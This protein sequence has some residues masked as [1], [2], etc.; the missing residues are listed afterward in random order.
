MEKRQIRNW[1]AKEKIISIDDDAFNSIVQT[2]AEAKP[3][4]NTLSA[5]AGSGQKAPSLVA[6]FSDLLWV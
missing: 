2:L 6:G 3:H 4:A 1:L 5:A